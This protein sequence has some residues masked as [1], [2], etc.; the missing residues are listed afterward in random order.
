MIR[1]VTVTNYRGDSIKLELAKPEKS[2]FVV[3]SITGLGPVKST[4]NTTEMSTTDGAL[5]N[6]ARTPSRNIVFNLGFLW[7]NTIEEVRLESY[8]YFP[9]KKK[10]KMLFETDARLAEIEGY[11][12]SNEPDIFSS[13][14]GATIS[15]ICPDP[16]FYLAGVENVTSFDGINPLFEFPF[17]NDSLTEPLLEMSEIVS[18]TENVVKYEGDVEIGITLNFHALG[19]VKNISIFNLDTRDVMRLNT[20]MQAGDD[21]IVNTVKGNKSVDL[22][23]DGQRT[24]IL[25]CLSKDS[26]WFTITKGTNRFAYE[27][28]GGKEYL[29]LTI[30]NRIIYEG[31]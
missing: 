8:K 3:K 4:I 5:Y 20:E 29:Q 30:R 18:I 19:P 12:E 25:R 27:S 11:V 10:I 15:V 22:I 24:S 28:E 23:R 14:E 17:C 26:D 21:I 2:G 1:S 6:S 31:V 16:Y 7:K 9:N 13:S